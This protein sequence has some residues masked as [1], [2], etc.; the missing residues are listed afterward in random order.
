MALKN[1]AS[2]SESFVYILVTWRIWN[3]SQSD[4]SFSLPHPCV[5][6][7]GISQHD[8]LLTGFMSCFMNLYA[9]TNFIPAAVLS[10]PHYHHAHFTDDMT[11][12]SKGMQQRIQSQ[13]DW[14]LTLSFP[15]HLLPSI[16][17]T[18]LLWQHSLELSDRGE[19]G[20][21]G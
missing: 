13:A 9:W 10:A 3:I 19:G 7:K 18:L 4:L 1:S 5:N 21:S 15:T 17:T 2:Y 14:F 20:G 12:T 8:L 6:N 11:E 16:S